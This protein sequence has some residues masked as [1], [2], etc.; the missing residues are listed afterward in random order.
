MFNSDPTLDANIP[1]K[2]RSLLQSIS[3][4]SSMTFLSRLMGFSRDMILASYFGAQSGMD[5]FL[6]AFRLPNSLRRLFAEGA[7]S[8]AFVPVLTDYQKK[9]THDVRTF[10]A[11]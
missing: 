5:A 9:T 2:Q 10:L 1:L 6:V 4:I 7:F 8:Q 3:L 11:R